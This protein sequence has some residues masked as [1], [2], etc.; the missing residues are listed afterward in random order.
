MLDFIL[1]L[2]SSFKPL[3]L[4]TSP[5]PVKE[6]VHVMLPSQ[7]LDL[8]K[9]YEG[10]RLKPYLDSV[11]VPTIGYGT[12]YYP[13]GTLV[14]ITDPEITV[15]KAEELLSIHAYS[16]WQQVKDLTSPY[17]LSDNQYSALTS[18]SYNLGIGALLKS[19]L[20]KK[21]KV[22]PSDPTIRLEFQKWTKAGG[23]S[24]KG[25]ELRRNEEAILYFTII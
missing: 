24:L 22:N 5:S 8:I 3:K 20:L 14:K 11:N 7:C 10:L 17:K 25:L 1:K 15:D 2:L 21:L 12:T 6:K 18:F 16:F 13:D 4:S 9:K 23:V 19:T